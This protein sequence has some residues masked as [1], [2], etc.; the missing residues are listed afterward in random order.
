MRL[1]KAN[2]A[3]FL[4]T[5]ILLVANLWKFFTYRSWERHYYTAALG[6]AN[7]YPIELS[8]FL[9]TRNSEFIDLFE[10]DYNS[11]GDVNAS[12]RS[13]V[14][15]SLPDSLKI[16][17]IAL[18]ERKIYKGAFKLPSSKIDSFFHLKNQYKI[19]FGGE[20]FGYNFDIGIAPGGSI[21]VWIDGYCHTYQK[22]LAHFKAE[23]I[24]KWKGLTGENLDNYILKSKIPDKDIDSLIQHNIPPDKNQWEERR[25]RYTY[26]IWLDS[27]FVA[28][29]FQIDFCNEEK[30]VFDFSK[31]R[32]ILVNNTPPIR[33]VSKDIDE[34]YPASTAI[35]I[36]KAE[37]LLLSHADTLILYLHTN[38]DDGS[39][40][41]T[42]TKTSEFGQE[43]LHNKT[44]TGSK[45]P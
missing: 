18:R 27:N 7:L 14:Y 39:L 12:D 17:Y 4:V 41:V 8:A 5:I 22:E 3:F 45:T 23:E 35:R 31:T 10:N 38:I 32:R 36:F 21:T 28:K 16:W 1:H 20:T 2:I 11:W 34:R 15:Q 40:I 29:S 13:M 19:N 25:K 44:I 33:F 9:K 6:V 37:K 30:D 43:L 26:Y 24:Q 42:V